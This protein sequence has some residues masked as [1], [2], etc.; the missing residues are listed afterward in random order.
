MIRSR[1]VRGLALTVAGVLV[2][3][4]TGC[5]SSDSDASGSSGP[6][7]EIEH[8]YG[9]T[10]I[11]DAPERIVSLDQQWTDAFLALGVE[12]I[13]YRDDPLMPDSGPPWWDDERSGEPIAVEQGIPVEQIAA[14][15]PDLIVGTYSITDQQTYDQLS[16]IAPTIASES[17]TQVQSWSEVT[18]TA[19]KILD[20]PEKAEDVVASVESDIE[21]TAH[22]LPGLENKTFVLAQYVVGD[23]MYVVTDPDDGSSKLFEDLGMQLLPAAVSEGEK[24]DLARAQVSTER[25][26][27]LDADFLAFLVNGGDE[28]DLDDIPGFDKLPS[29]RAGSAAVLDYGTVVGVNTP[30]PLSIPYVL[31]ELHPYLGRV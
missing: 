1:V 17:A 24:S 21:R 14:L 10:E 31:D 29:V 28:S 26:D 30:T 22:D 3:A 19:G 8:Q 16:A 7:V 4:L 6:A 25:V 13:G 12:P 11:G 23:G 20:E 15:E 27:L 2:S 9:T 5:G 18:T